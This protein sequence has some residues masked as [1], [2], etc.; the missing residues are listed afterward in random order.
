VDEVTG[1][2]RT[3]GEWLAGQLYGLGCDAANGSRPDLHQGDGREF[4][5]DQILSGAGGFAWWSVHEAAV[6]LDE[7]GLR[8]ASGGQDVAALGWAWRIAMEAR[9]R[10]LS[11]EAVT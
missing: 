10:L 4:V 9:H 11:Q 2:E 8:A 5:L 7:M 3:P 6:L 1:R